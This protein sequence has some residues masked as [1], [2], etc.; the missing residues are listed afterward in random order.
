MSR[1]LQFR[2]SLP[3]AAD[4]CCCCGNNC[5]VEEA[6]LALSCDDRALTIDV[7]VPGSD[8]RV[9]APEVRF[10]TT[11]SSSS[12]AER[13]EGFKFPAIAN[14][15]TASH[16]SLDDPCPLPQAAPRRTRRTAPPPRRRSCSPALP[17]P[18]P[19]RSPAACWTRPPLR[20]RPG[21]PS[22]C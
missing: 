16:Q 3:G 2:G 22:P 19:L 7:G 18:G 5:F 14:S 17:P 13:K 9:V 1:L 8:T 12:S 21:R 20:R 15:G 11:V 4:G 6:L 10:T